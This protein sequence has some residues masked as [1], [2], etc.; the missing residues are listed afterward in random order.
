MCPNMQFKSVEAFRLTMIAVKETRPMM[1][2][3]RSRMSP[4]GRTKMRPEAYP[5]CISVGTWDEV[6]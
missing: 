6:S 5:A 4:K 1:K 3:R 2:N